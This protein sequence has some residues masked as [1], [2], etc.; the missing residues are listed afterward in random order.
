MNLK[1]HITNI[2]KGSIAARTKVEAIA[3]V[4]LLYTGERPII[5]DHGDYYEVNFTE[6]QIK[7]LQ[8]TLKA[9]HDA[10]P[11]EIR[12]NVKPVLLP[13]YIKRY[14]AYLAGIG[15]SGLLLGLFIKR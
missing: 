12:I 9:W 5:T 2:L 6:S 10:E 13:F 11:G 4:T 1:N 8:D 7:K 15:I 14:A 3:A